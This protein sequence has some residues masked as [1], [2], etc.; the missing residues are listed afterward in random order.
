MFAVLL[1]LRY[2]ISIP[3]SLKNLEVGATTMHTI[4][5]ITLATIS[6]S[7]VIYKEGASEHASPLYLEGGDPLFLFI[8][9]RGAC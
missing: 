3:I 1:L 7:V 8:L 2:H 6:E 5:I 4:I 9:W